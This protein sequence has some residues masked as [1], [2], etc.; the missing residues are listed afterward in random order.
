MRKKD[1]DFMKYFIKITTTFIIILYLITIP[2]LVI[3]ATVQDP[4]LKIA[5]SDSSRGELSWESIKDKGDS[6]LNKGE[7]KKH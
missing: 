6:F 1:G 5:T 7:R 4:K 2:K 3:A